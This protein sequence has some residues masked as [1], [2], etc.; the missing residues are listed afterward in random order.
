MLGLTNFDEYDQIFL[1]FASL[2]AEL[3]QKPTTETM[4]F[5]IILLNQWVSRF[6]GCPFGV[7]DTKTKTKRI[8]PCRTTARQPSSSSDGRDHPSRESTLG[9]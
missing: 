4:K 6:F 8:A 5:R 2:S 3:V 1:N 9:W 7:R